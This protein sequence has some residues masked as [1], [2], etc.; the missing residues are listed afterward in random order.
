MNGV[1]LGDGAEITINGTEVGYQCWLEQVYIFMI[2]K[3]IYSSKV[4]KYWLEGLMGAY[5]ENS[6]EKTS[7]QGEDITI[8]GKKYDGIYLDGS[9]SLDL[10]GVNTRIEGKINGIQLWN[11]GNSSKITI[12]S[13]MIS[14][15]GE[16][17]DGI[18]VEE[19]GGIV[20]IVGK[21]LLFQDIKMVLRH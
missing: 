21:M 13:D 7:I 11:N 9:G 18:L 12:E 2:L 6:T 5:F 8:T 3:E 15:S 4:D 17:G 16:T 1:S 19:E 10:K 20:E 14:L